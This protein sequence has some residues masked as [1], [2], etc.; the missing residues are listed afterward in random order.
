MTWSIIAHDPDTGAI[1]CAVTSCFFAVGAVVPH[2]QAGVGAIATQAFA[3]RALG[4]KGLALLEAGRT[5]DAAIAALLADDPGREVRQVHL[6]GKD[7]TSAGHTGARCPYWSG[8]VSGPGVSAA[9][10][11]LVAEEVVQATLEAFLA[12]AGS[13]EERL[14][15]A[16]QAGQRAGGDSRGWQSAAL[17]VRGRPGLPDVDIRADD[18]AAP[19]DELERLLAVHI[20]DYLPV[21]RYFPGIAGAIGAFDAETLEAARATRLANRKS[22]LAPSHG[23]LAPARPAPAGN[24]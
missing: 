6:I 24:A 3:N 1:G 10:N 18:H 4:P 14:V 21:A 9:G 2:V 22:G 19:L 23:T 20:H 7:G 17:L 8:S 13:L 12:A 15:T 5:P 16:L 11:T